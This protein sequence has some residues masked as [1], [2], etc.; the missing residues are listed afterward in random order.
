VDFDELSVDEVDFYNRLSKQAGAKPASAVFDIMYPGESKPAITP[1]ITITS[2]PRRM[3]KSTMMEKYFKIRE[4]LYLP[5]LRG[6]GAEWIAIDEFENSILSVGSATSKH[7]AKEEEMAKV[8][9]PKLSAEAIAHLNH[10]AEQMTEKLSGMLPSEKT[11]SLFGPAV[12]PVFVHS[13]GYRQ[14][15][16]I[17]GETFTIE[18]V[19]VGSPKNGH[20]L[21]FDYK[22]VDAA[23]YLHMEINQ[24]DSLSQ[25]SDWRMVVDKAAGG[26]FYMALEEVRNIDA[27]KVYAKEQERHQQ[28]YK[29][30]GAW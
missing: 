27:A 9:R 6:I 3:G 19:H 29:E 25:I 10:L 2:N 21:I 13:K 12:H 16:H 15:N 26:N 1:K 17:G 5:T 30:F 18:R 14:Q 11:V 24:D 23:T 7:K 20:Q 28:D 8:E 4:E 22:P